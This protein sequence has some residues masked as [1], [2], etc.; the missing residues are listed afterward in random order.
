MKRFLPYVVAILAIGVTGY[1][2]ALQTRNS[3]APQ[4]LHD[5]VTR[6]EQVPLK[7]GPWEGEPHTIPSQEIAAGK[8]NGYLMRNYV[9][10]DDGSSVTL[11][12]VCGR[13]G[14]ISVHTPDICY[15]GL[16]Y[17]LTAP[18]GSYAMP[19]AQFVVGDFR[20]QSP[21]RKPDLRILWSW[22]AG[23]GWKAPSHPRFTFAPN[24][25]LYKAYVVREAPWNSLRPMDDEDPS[26]RFLAALVPVLE[27]VLQPRPSS[28]PSPSAA[29]A[30]NHGKA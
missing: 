14:P 27:Q 21:I 5:A 28:P 6:L 26:A 12:I 8:I 9:N 29:P 24:P 4:A 11:M 18:A 22:N 2:R 15:A 17:E 13:P 23:K 7:I 10:R 19:S 30:P 16:G 25:F 1:L 3:L 20:E